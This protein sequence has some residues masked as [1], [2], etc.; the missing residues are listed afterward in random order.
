MGDE[1]DQTKPHGHTQPRRNFLQFGGLG[2]VV[3]GGALE[4]PSDCPRVLPNFG[5]LKGLPLE[6]VNTETFSMT[7]LNSG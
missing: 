2:Q 3:L 5:A 6:A 1:S 7:L 4:N